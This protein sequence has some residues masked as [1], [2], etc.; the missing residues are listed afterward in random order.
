MESTNKKSKSLITFRLIVGLGI[1]HQIFCI[2]NVLAGSVVIEP[3]IARWLYQLSASAMHIFL[4]WK[5]VKLLR[6]ANLT[7]LKSLQTAIYLSIPIWI[8]C[9]FFIM[10][11]VS[12]PAGGAAAAFL[13]VTCLFYMGIGAWIGS[14][15]HVQDISAYEIWKS[16]Q[17]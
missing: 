5:I 9:F 10:K 6:S 14:K 2:L 15:K 17:A 7:N 16:T 3:L 12:G 13:P 8:L 1:F 4:I 11:Y